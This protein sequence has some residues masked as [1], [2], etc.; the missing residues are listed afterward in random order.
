MKIASIGTRVVHAG[1][2][3]WVFVRIDTDQPGL[4]GW[5]EASLEWRTRSVVGAVDD[6]AT[7]LVGEDPT[8]TE[9]LWQVMHRSPFFRDGVTGMS[10][11]S[12][13]DQALHDI[14]AKELGVPLYRL[15]GGAVRDRV[16]FYD[17]LAMDPL[18]KGAEALGDRAR[19]SVAAGFDAVKYLACP[20]T[21]YLEG[22]ARIGEVERWMAAVRDAVGDAVDIMLDFHGRPRGP[23]AAIAYGLAVK[24]YRPWFIEEPLPPEQSAGLGSVRLATGLPIA[25]GERL[26]TRFEFRPLLESRAID[27]AQP[28]VCHAGG[29]TELLKIGAL[30]DTYGVA[31]AP[32][33]PLGPIATMVNLQI[34]L[35]MPNFIIQEQTRGDVP[36]RD[37]IVDEPLVIARGVA[38]PPDR[39]GIGV[40]LDEDEAARHPYQPEQPM[41]RALVDGTLADW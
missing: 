35:A 3:N 19:A 26:V 32:H 5:G 36:W 7:F 16:R 22:A 25:T 10:A 2:R 24:P 31:M 17:N 38:R 23:A 28:D 37:D 30:A 1:I 33:N 13:I 20:P 41:R 14:R 40:E 4:V 11:L 8:R 9:H 29:V 39:P 18:E 6:L 15:L 27:I 21:G 12:G 34:A